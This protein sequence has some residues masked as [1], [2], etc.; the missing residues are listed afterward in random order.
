ML[1]ER[2]RVQAEVR[3]QLWQALLRVNNP[4]ATDAQ[5]ALARLAE[6]NSLQTLKQEVANLPV[7]PFDTRLLGRLSAVLL[8][9]IA[10]VVARFVQ[11]TLR[12]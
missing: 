6:L 5:T 9:I 12:L 8:S 4:H 10:I 3:G 2:Q 1:A 7:W 11:L